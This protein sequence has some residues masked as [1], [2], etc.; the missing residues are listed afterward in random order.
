MAD[1]LRN[2]EDGAI[3]TLL[4]P[5]TEVGLDRAIAEQGGKL[6]VEG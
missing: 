6:Q 2:A 4:A 1:V 5:F 3:R